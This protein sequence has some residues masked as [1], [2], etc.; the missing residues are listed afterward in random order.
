[1]LNDDVLEVEVEKPK[2][3]QYEP[4]QFVFLSFKAKGLKEL[5]PFSFVSSPKEDHLRFA[6]KKLGDYTQRLPEHMPNASY[7]HVEGPYGDFTLSKSKSN[8]QLWI[9]GGV[10]V[11]PFISF[12]SSLSEA[13]CK[14][15]KIHMIYCVNK[16]EE[17]VYLDFLERKAAELDCFDF[18]LHE[19]ESLGFINAK[20]AEEISRVS[21]MVE[22]PDVFVCAPPAMI[23]ALKEQFKTLGYRKDKIISEEFNF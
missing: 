11:T 15:K 2:N 19:S 5:H 10:G 9:A 20:K 1:M 8:I 23:R 14:D 6:I 16:K 17:A 18:T 3:F 21:E 7:A 4:G 22:K 13:D 12:L